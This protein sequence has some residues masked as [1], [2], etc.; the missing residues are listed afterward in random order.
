MNWEA[1]LLAF[2]AWVG[3][4]VAWFLAALFD[5]TANRKRY[6]IQR[7]RVQGGCD[8][9]DDY[10]AEVGDIET[11][12]ANQGMG[13]P[14]PVVSAAQTAVQ[15][16]LVLAIIVLPSFRVSNSMGWFALTC[17]ILFVVAVIGLAIVHELFWKDGLD[18]AKAKWWVLIIAL[19][20]VELMLIVWIASAAYSTDS[21]NDPSAFVPARRQFEP[22]VLE[23][24]PSFAADKT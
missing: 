16:L 24:H 21:G 8:Q 5:Y 13:A 2:I 11:H 9:N 19:W 4:V 22:I 6:E 3:G 20:L 23:S 10:A 12:L 18:A 7:A 14:R 1:I 17:N 15:P